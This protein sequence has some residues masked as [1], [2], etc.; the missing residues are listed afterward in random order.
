MDITST[1]TPVYSTS[2]EGEA[3]FEALSAELVNELD[4]RMETPEWEYCFVCSR[5]TDHRAEHDDLLE[6]GLVR[7]GEG[8]DGSVYLIRVPAEARS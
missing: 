3:I 1:A 7:Y 4:L 5:A 6:Q 8:F 2:T